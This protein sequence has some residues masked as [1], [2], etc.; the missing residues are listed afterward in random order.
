MRKFRVLALAG[1]A[2]LAMLAVPLASQ[3]TPYSFTPRITFPEHAG[4]YQT[5]SVPFTGR[6][7]PGTQVRLVLGDPPC[8]PGGC[9]LN[10]TVA[11]PILIDPAGDWTAPVGLPEG[12]HIVYMWWNNGLSDRV[13]DIVE[14]TLDVTAPAAPTIDFPFGGETFTSTVVPISGTAEPRAHVVIVDELGN[15]RSTT[16]AEDGTWSY[17]AI[18]R[19]GPHTI[20][21][22]QD[23]LAFNASPM[24]LPVSFTVDV[25]ETPPVAPTILTPSNGDLL[26]ATVVVSGISEPLSTVE[27]FEDRPPGFIIY[28]SVIAAGDGTWSLTLSLSDGL[29]GLRA[30]ATDAAGNL[31]PASDEVAFQ[32]DAVNPTAKTKKPQYYLI[33]S[34]NFIDG[35]TIRGYASDNVAVA[36]IQVQYFDLIGNLVQD[37]VALC[38]GCGTQ[39]ATWEDTPAALAP[40][41]YFIEATAFDTVGNASSVADFNLLV[42]P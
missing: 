22:Y 21:A 38:S 16:A 3:A 31:G 8:S 26:P 41:I 2:A 14:F 36:S 28:G 39:S 40:G 35:D 25:D 6:G 11:G 12:Q 1:V 7:V 15:V 17:A 19:A 33:G 20:S 37:N 27:V 24:S 10:P 13:V 29:H 30:R 23:D 5:T 32:V 18:F 4:G 42:L 34:W 9:A